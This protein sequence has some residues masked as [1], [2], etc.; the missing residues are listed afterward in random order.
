MYMLIQSSF[1]HRLLKKNYKY[2]LK[3]KIMFK[4]VC[5][6]HVAIHISNTIVINYDIVIFL[7]INVTVTDYGIELKKILQYHS[8]LVF[9]KKKKKFVTRHLYCCTLTI[10]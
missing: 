8:Q 6:G 4:L 2:K 1:E 10:K 3:T 9:F 7:K 5:L